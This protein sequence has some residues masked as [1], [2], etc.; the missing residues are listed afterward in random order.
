MRVITPPPCPI[1]YLGEG[2]KIGNLG[3]WGS[4]AAPNTQI[5]GFY[6]PFLPVLRGEKGGRGDKRGNLPVSQPTTGLRNKLE[7]W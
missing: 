7:N 2:G 6:P 1:F 3:V 4:L 5:S